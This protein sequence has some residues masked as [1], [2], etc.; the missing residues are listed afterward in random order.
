MKFPIEVA[1]AALRLSATPDGQRVFGFLRQAVLNQINPPGIAG[2]V[3]LH[4]EGQRYIVGSIY[5]AI[6]DA[7]QKA[8][9]APEQPRRRRLKISTNPQGGQDG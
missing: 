7:T 1:E 6:A 4:I 9:P 8:A 2:D 5:L 3:S